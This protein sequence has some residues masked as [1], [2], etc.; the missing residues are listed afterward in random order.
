[1][2]QVIIYYAIVD[3]SDKILYNVMLPTTVLEGSTVLDG[4]YSN[5]DAAIAKCKEILTQYVHNTEK[6]TRSF[7]DSDLDKNN[8]NKHDNAK[9]DFKMHSFAFNVNK[10]SENFAEVQCSVEH[11]ARSYEIRNINKTIVGEDGLEYSRNES[12]KEYKSDW[13]SITNLY[14]PHISL[15]VIEKTL[16]IND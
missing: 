15:Y 8:I 4:F 14:D 9:F 1:M 6:C 16:V 10:Q 11:L 7:L 3:T 5:Q 2:S 13:F 12:K